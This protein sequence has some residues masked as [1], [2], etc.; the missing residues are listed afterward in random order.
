MYGVTLTPGRLGSGSN[1]TTVLDLEGDEPSKPWAPSMTCSTRADDERTERRGRP[2]SAGMSE[3]KETMQ[4]DTTEEVRPRDASRS[5]GRRTNSRFHLHVHVDAFKAGL[6]FPEDSADIHVQVRLPENVA[7][8]MNSTSEPG[9][10]LQRRWKTGTTSL[11]TKGT[12]TK[13][14]DGSKRLAF[15]ASPIDLALQLSESPTLELSVWKTGASPPRACLGKAEVSLDTLLEHQSIKATARVLEVGKRRRNETRTVGQI[16][17]RIVLEEHW[18]AGNPRNPSASEESCAG[19]S[20]VEL[21]DTAQSKTRCGPHPEP[22]GRSENCELHEYTYARELEAWKVVEQK[23]WIEGMKQKEQQVMDML[24]NEWK[25]Q[26]LRRGAE[27]DL[28]VREL[29]SLEKKLRERL[30][31]VEERERKIAFVEEELVRRKAEVE[32]AFQSKCTK[33]Q[34]TVGRLQK[35]FEHELEL[36][37]KREQEAL[38]Q[39]KEWEGRAQEAKLHR[40]K[41]V[42]EFE[43]FKNKHRSAPETQLSGEVFRMNVVKMDLERRLKEAN[44]TNEASK[45]RIESLQ[46]QLFHEVR[47]KE[48][49]EWKRI[50]IERDQIESLSSTF[51][52]NT[53]IDKLQSYK[54]EI[55][56]LKDG[57]AN[58][59]TGSHPAQ[60]TNKNARE[61]DPQR[62]TSHATASDEVERAPVDAEHLLRER[63]ELLCT[64]LYSQADP[65]IQELDRRIF[66]EGTGRSTFGLYRE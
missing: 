56:S 31:A 27:V 53:E 9:T 58:L 19:P 60:A 10:K 26:E 34:E 1:H 33:A 30:H 3:E 43:E 28:Q 29:A 12:S 36:A 57:L 6:F 15:E 2:C 62:A 21:E 11:Q 4:P 66:G 13:I 22:S 18:P 48:V 61:P 50:A 23:K 54:D 59:H 46:Q 52:A 20:Y 64:G 45:A 38:R 37:C 41:I 63:N 7:R 42:A 49:E 39:S 16:Q 25:R 44:E 14:Q 35:E 8:L 5:D 47:A 65:V 32:L 24:E 40:N 17:L 51:Y 55:A